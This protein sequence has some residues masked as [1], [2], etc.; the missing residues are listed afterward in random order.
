MMKQPSIEEG[1]DFSPRFDS[2]GLIPAVA[3]EAA[4]GEILMVAYMNKEALDETIRCGYAVYY[5]RSRGRLWRKGEESGHTQKVEQ[6]LVDCDQDCLILRVSVDHGQCH[7]GHY[8]C[9]YRALRKDQPGKLEFIA[10]A[11]YDPKA[12][13]E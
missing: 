10:K 5:S 12:V 3:Q 7:T 1:V 9:F 8:S 6:I 11:V 4:S 2:L 13:Y